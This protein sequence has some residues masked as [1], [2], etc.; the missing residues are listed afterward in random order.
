MRSRPADT[1]PDA[2]ELQF[3]LLRRVPLARRVQLALALSDTVSRLARQACRHA[4]PAA[5]HEEIG[6][7]FIE[8]HYGRELAEA[9][10]Q[11]L[12]ARRG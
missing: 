11:D 5:S 9:V 4:H 2:Y 8:A 6:L 7:R 1:D 10:R 12:A 3:A